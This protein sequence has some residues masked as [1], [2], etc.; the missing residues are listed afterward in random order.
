[1]GSISDAAAL[2]YR[3]YATDGVPSSGNYSPTKAAIRGKRCEYRP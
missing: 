3:D 2:L 1:M